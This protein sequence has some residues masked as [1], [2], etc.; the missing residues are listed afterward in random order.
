[1]F[2]TEPKLGSFRNGDKWYG[3]FLAKFSVFAPSATG[4]ANWYLRSKRKCPGFSSCFYYV[5]TSVLLENTPLVIGWYMIE[6]SSGLPR[7][8]SKIFGKW[9]GTFVWP[10]DQNNFWKIFGNLRKLVENLRK[11]VKTAVIRYNQRTSHVNS[12]IWILSSRDKN[13]ILF[14]PLEHKFIS[15]R[16]RIIS[17]IFWRGVDLSRPFSYKHLL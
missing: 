12:K 8:S 13:H 11:I 15:S 1:M 17:F 7:K 9:S 5:D 3:N 14:L 6:T 2:S 10:S 4:N 16:H